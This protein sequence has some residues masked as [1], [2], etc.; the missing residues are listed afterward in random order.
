LLSDARA[1]LNLNRALSFKHYIEPDIAKKKEIDTTIN[2]NVTAYKADLDTF[3]ASI[4]TADTRREY[5]GLRR[6]I[7][8]YIPQNERS[9]QISLAGDTQGAYQYAADNATLAGNKVTEQFAALQKLKLERAVIQDADGQSTYR[10]ARTLMLVLVLVALL[11]GAALAV[12][13]TRSIRGGVREVIDRLRSLT[14]K[15]T[16]ELRGGLEAMAAG[17]LTRTVQAQTPPIARWSNDE[18]GDVAQAVNA[19]RDNTAASLDAYSATREAL[20]GMIGEVTTVAGAVASS[21]QEV[22]ATSEEAGRAVSEI[23]HAVTDVASG[24]E[25]QVRMVDDARQSAQQTAEAAGRARCVAED[26]ARASEQATAAM[27]SVRTAS[28]EAAQAIRS[29]AAKGAQVSGIADTIGGI[30][31]QTNLLA[32]NAAIEAARA[33]DQGRA[34]RWSP[35]RCASSRRRASGLPARS[36]A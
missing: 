22:A 17:D 13:I 33:G 3:A 18:I 1:T 26:G 19:V 11:L 7:D 30:A 12:L 6:A 21:S 35:K 8:Q 9:R 2:A 27:A 34:S 32:L 10:N 24:A 20:A 15:D 23:A 36:P 14:G 25:R 28:G 16:T 31:Q 29:L 4:T 5:D